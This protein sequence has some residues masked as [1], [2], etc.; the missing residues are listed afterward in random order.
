M[1]TTVSSSQ[2]GLVKPA[3]EVFWTALRAVDVAPRDAVMVG[4]SSEDDVAGALAI[5][6]GAILLDRSG[7]NGRPVATIRSLAELPAALSL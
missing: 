7:R 6:C 3:P 4:D 2:V 5:G 1:V